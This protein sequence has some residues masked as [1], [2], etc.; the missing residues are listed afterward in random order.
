[1]MTQ[2]ERAV[3][4]AASEIFDEGVF[5]V[6]GA[7]TEEKAYCREVAAAVLR[8]AL[9]ALFEARQWEGW[10]SFSDA[11]AVNEYRIWLD[12]HRRA[13]EAEASHE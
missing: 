4:A 11:L 8:A 7:E 13:L 3:E 1:M 5:D 6:D 9:P 12:A 2:W 10:D